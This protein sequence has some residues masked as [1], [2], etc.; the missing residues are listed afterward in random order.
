MD[1]STKQ[2]DLLLAIGPHERYGL[3]I[4]LA[5]KEN[6]GRGMSLGAMYTQLERL[7]GRG[8]LKSR[9]GE[10]THERGGNR[11]K[12]FKVSG[13]GQRALREFFEA[14]DQRRSIWGLGVQG[15]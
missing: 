7:E 3:E 8:L 1:L 15:C 10:A 13:K 2:A 12:Y 14:Q 6:T 5:F 11:R 9:E 4:N